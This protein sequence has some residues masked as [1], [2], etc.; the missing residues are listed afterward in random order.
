MKKLIFMFLAV[1]ATFVA[2]NTPE[3]TEPV[4]EESIELMAESVTFQAE[5]AAPQQVEVILLN[6][7]DWDV[8]VLDGDWLTVEKIEA[9]SMAIQL[10]VTDNLS[11]QSRETVVYVSGQTAT[12]ELLVTQLGIAPALVAIRLSSQARVATR[13]FRLLRTWRGRQLPLPTG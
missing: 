3:P 8:A 10:T 12:A 9:D 5:G 6:C 7:T 13:L 4:F 2:C 11:D 1:F